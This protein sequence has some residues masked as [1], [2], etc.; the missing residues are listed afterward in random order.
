MI[1]S[2]KSGSIPLSI[3]CKSFTTNNLQSEGLSMEIV[4]NKDI[5]QVTFLI[6]TSANFEAED[7]KKDA[8]KFK[9]NAEQFKSL[10]VTD[11]ALIMSV[12]NKLN[13]L[14]NADKAVFKLKVT[15]D[16]EGTEK[17]WKVFMNFQADRLKLSKA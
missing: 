2:I 7:S 4:K 1:S 9:K 14:S 5:P 17:S 12:F 11:P 13:S 6:D 15:L 16:K 3:S 8:A 10:T